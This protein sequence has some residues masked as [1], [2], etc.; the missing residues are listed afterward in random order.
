VLDLPTNNTT[1]MNSYH[2]MGVDTDLPH[3]PWLL[4]WI[5]EVYDY[6]IL[7]GFGKK[8]TPCKYKKTRSVI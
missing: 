1:D 4:P 2:D 6:N 3:G 8:E 7:Y 5:S